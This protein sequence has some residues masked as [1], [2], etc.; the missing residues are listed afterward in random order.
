MGAGIGCILGLK[1]LQVLRHK[2]LFGD[3]AIGRIS[4]ILM[5]IRSTSRFVLLAGERFGVILWQ[6]MLEWYPGQRE[7]QTTQGTGPVPW[8][9]TRDKRSTSRCEVKDHQVY[10][11]LAQANSNRTSERTPVLLRYRVKLSTQKVTGS[12]LDNREHRIR[13]R[14]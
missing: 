11:N 1:L 14:A 7:D 4:R 5:A 10:P 8:P 2:G 6:K 13:T 12:L 3:A 9:G